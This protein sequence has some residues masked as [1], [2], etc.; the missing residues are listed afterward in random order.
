MSASEE[1][2]ALKSI[3]KEVAEELRKFTAATLSYRK[4]I[5]IVIN[6]LLSD[7]DK[8]ALEAADEVT[9]APKTKRVSYG[10][11]ETETSVK[12]EQFLTE[13]ATTKGNVPPPLPAGKRACSICRKPGHR[14]KNCPEQEQADLATAVKKQIAKKK[15]KKK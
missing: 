8:L 11:T 9:E 6:H 4:R 3:A 2:A 14:A 15:A 5:D 12:L 1:R 13:G 7:V 10:T